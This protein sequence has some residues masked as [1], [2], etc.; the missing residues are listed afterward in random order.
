MKKIA[1]FL[2]V[3]LFM[4]TLTASAQTRTITGRV[5][6]GDDGSSIPGVS[7]VVKGTTLGTIS[8]IDGNFTIQV[9]ADAQTLVFS[10]VGMATQEIAIEG[11][12]VVN[13]VMNPESIGVEEVIVVAYGT[14][15]R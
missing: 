2:S 5:T 6:S 9:P 7:I 15:T 8:N 4:G 3:L 13:V 14:T 10:F 12:S 11:L 1:F